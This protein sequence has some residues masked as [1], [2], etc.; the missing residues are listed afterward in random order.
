VA[1]VNGKLQ[2]VSRVIAS[3]SNPFEVFILL[4]WEKK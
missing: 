4:G 2:K 3:E 1:K